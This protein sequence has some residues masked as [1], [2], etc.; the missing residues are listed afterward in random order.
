MLETLPIW[1][2]IFIGSMLPGVEAKVVVPLTIYQY[3]C[4]WWIAFIIGVAGNMILVPFGL[5]FLHKIEDFLSRFRSFKRTMDIIFPRIRKRADKKIQRY[6]SLALLMFVA[7]P[8]PLTG[9][10]IGVLIAYLFDLKFSRSLL[11]IF[12][13]VL[14]ATSITTFLY[15]G[16]SYLFYR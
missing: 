8:L 11:M 10:G 14:I 6:E 7:I 15:L 16:F 2:Q 4:E 1:L 5:I 12:I 13:G 9:A 3:H